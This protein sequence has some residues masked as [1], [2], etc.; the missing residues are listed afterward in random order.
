MFLA[1]TIVQRTEPGQ[2][3]TVKNEDYFCHVHVKAETGLAAI[4]IADSAYP[5]TAA[6]SIIAKVGARH[7]HTHAG[8]QTRGPHI[9]HLHLVFNVSQGRARKVKA[10][11]SKNNHGFYCTCDSQP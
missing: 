11:F 2:R 5:T 1:R 7:V 9:L 8:T 6:F 4:V 10:K 3:Q